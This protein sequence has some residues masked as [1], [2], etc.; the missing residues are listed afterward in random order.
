M[1]TEPKS[2]TDQNCNTSEEG[3]E[4]IHLFSQSFKM[5]FSLRNR[6][7]NS[8]R[9]EPSAKI[10]VLRFIEMLWC[11]MICQFSELF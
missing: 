11:E 9:C 4:K 5:E 7:F 8:G 3:A 10:N 2:F 6:I 1:K